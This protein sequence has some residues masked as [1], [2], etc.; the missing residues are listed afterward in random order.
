[1]IAEEVHMVLLSI[2][3][4]SFQTKGSVYMGVDVI[5]TPSCT[6]SRSI[7]YGLA[8]MHVHDVHTCALSWTEKP[9]PIP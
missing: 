7:H 6:F 8:I 4:P 2:L 5:Q 9:I 1:M 3:S